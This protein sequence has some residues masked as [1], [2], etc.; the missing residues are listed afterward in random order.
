[1]KRYNSYPEY[2]REIFGERVQKL[3]INAGLTCPNRDGTCGV[4]GC[5]FCNALAFNPSYCNPA[6]S[7]SQQMEEGRE[8]HLTRYRRASKYLAYFQ[9]FSNTYCKLDK[10]VAMCKEALEFP[11][12]VGIVIGTRPDCI[13]EQKLDFLQELACNHYIK[14][15]YGIESTNDDTLKRVNRGHDYKSLVEAVNFTAKRQLHIGGHLIFGLP[16]ETKEMI[17]AQAKLVSELP[18]E[19]IKFHQLQIM[20]NTK[21]ADE[22]VQN[23]SDFYFYELEEYLELVIRF[24]ERLR[25]EIAIERIASEVPPRFL[26]MPPKWDMRYDVV[27][28]RFEE[29]LEEFDTFQGKFYV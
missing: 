8:F 9:T 27:L 29:K 17:V 23:P 6:K 15:E 20:K 14:I 2:F 4:G 24:V 1:M 26:L 10:L 5:T 16:G 22:F 21:M 25:P 19:T 7:I 11:N 28:R 13:D 12:V 18:L 3:S